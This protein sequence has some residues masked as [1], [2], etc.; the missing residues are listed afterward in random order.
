MR[1]DEELGRLRKINRSVEEQFYRRFW[2]PR[3]KNDVS[4]QAAI[5]IWSVNRPEG[6]EAYNR[7]VIDTAQEE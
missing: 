3:K 2:V 5:L 1:Y 6:R 4:L 7:A